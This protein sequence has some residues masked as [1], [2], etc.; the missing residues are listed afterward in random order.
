MNLK[1]YYSLLLLFRFAEIY[2]ILFIKLNQRIQIWNLGLLNGHNICF[3]RSRFIWRV[4]CYV[5]KLYR[6]IFILL[7][8]FNS[9]ILLWR[10]YF[11]IFDRKTCRSLFDHI[12]WS[13]LLLVVPDIFIRLVKNVDSSSAVI[14]YVW[15][16]ADFWSWMLLLLSFFNIFGGYFKNWIVEDGSF[17]DFLHITWHWRFHIDGSCGR[18]RRINRIR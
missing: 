18:C 5:I 13:F 1:R 6:K 3:S 16:I 14:K 2:T 15:L 4:R 17:I 12:I 9:L 11:I 7:W 10:L 8:S